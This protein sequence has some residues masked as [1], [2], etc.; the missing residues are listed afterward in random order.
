MIAGRPDA[1]ALVDG[2]GI[3]ARAPPEVSE[4]V[5]PDDLTS[6]YATEASQGSSRFFTP[7]SSDVA[8]VEQEHAGNL[9]SIIPGVRS[10]APV[11]PRSR[12]AGAGPHR[13]EQARQGWRGKQTASLPD[14]CFKCFLQGHRSPECPN[15]NR[16]VRDPAFERHVFS[17]FSKLSQQQQERLRAINRLPLQ[18]LLQEAHATGARQAKEDANAVH[19]PDEKSKPWQPTQKADETPPEV[20][21]VEASNPDP[22]N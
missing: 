11:Q 18:L 15:G 9:M 2:D 6:L 4:D 17:N 16:V 1:I 7:N 19:P 3:V 13:R 22:E 20:A 5:H 8:Q 21:L 12:I 10:K 14:V